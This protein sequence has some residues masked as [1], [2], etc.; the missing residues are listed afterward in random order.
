VDSNCLTPDQLLDEPGWEIA[1]LDPNHLGWRSYPLR[2]VN[3]I[4]IGAYER[5]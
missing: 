3:Q 5:K 2:Q 4:K 1:S